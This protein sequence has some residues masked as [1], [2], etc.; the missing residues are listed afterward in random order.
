MS[1]KMKTLSLFILM[2][3]LLALSGL[4]YSQEPLHQQ[5]VNDITIANPYIRETIP[6]TT[7]SAAYMSIKNSSTEQRKLVAIS[8]NISPRIEMH[9]HLMVNDMMQ[10][11]KISA[12]T[13]PAQ[14]QVEL[15]PA[16]LHLMIFDLKKPLTAAQ[17]VNMTLHFDNKSTIIVPV[18]VVSLKQNQPHH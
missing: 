14:Q 5:N 15:Q 1:L 12:I 3:S 4:A 18:P 2:I 8:S 7:I 10:M 6:G 11:R 16:G 17:K 13:I 9:Q